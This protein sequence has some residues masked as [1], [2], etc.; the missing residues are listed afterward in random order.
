MNTDRKTGLM[1]LGLMIALGP[2]AVLWLL[3]NVGSAS[4]GAQNFGMLVGLSTF[5]LTPLGAII[6]LVGLV[7]AGFRKD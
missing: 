6:F 2:W 4:H 3:G 1:K 5:L 7:S